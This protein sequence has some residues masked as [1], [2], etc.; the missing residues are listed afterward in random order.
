MDRSTGS[1]EE[2]LADSDSNGD[3]DVYEVEK[4][5]NRRVKP[6][7]SL[8]QCFEYFVQWKG[9]KDGTWVPAVHMQ[10]VPKK[11]MEYGKLGLPDVEY[12]EEEEEEEE[13]EKE[14]EEEEE[15]EEE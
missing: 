14:E 7:T 3:S 13:D 2:E 15:E 6:G 10:S 12:V 5:V 4:I 1:S 8:K 9:Y 11:I